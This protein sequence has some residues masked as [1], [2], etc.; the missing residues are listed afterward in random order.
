MRRVFALLLVA[1]ACA[2]A[3]TCIDGDPDVA[4]SLLGSQDT[5]A[6]IND[7]VEITWHCKHTAGQA[8]T[9]RQDGTDVPFSF[10]A[11]A[12]Y[13]WSVRTVHRAAPS[14]GDTVQMQLAGT[15]ISLCTAKERLCQLP[16]DPDVTARES[17]DERGLFT[18]ARLTLSGEKGAFYFVT[19]LE[20]LCVLLFLAVNIAR[21]VWRVM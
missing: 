1:A 15:G 5:T 12:A 18:A 21:L 20:V 6:T 8:L 17:C 3:H 13:P 11:A 2:S 16:F 19:L 14:E 9:L 10:T 7:M 4:Y